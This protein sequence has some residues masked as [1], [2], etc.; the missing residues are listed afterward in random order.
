MVQE[1]PTSSPRQTSRTALSTWIVIA[2]CGVFRH[3]VSFPAHGPL[4]VHRESA[5]RSGE[6]CT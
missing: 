2:L 1:D 3:D 4:P 6:M 5:S